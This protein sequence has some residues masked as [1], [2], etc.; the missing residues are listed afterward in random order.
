[1][2]ILD[3]KTI[4]EKIKEA[5]PKECEVV[6]IAP[7]GL[8]I[9]VY[10]K[11]IRAFYGEEQ[12]IKK[13]A[14][15]IKR[16]ISVRSDPSVLTPPEEAKRIITELV[17][18]EAQLG[19]I[20]FVPE[21]SKVL[22]EAF[23]PGVVI[24]K[25]GQTLREIILRT[26]WSPK[27]LRIPTIESSTLSGMR[28]SYV[29]NAKAIKKFLGTLGKKLTLNGSDGSPSWIRVSFLGA[30]QEVGRSCYYIQTNKERFLLD[31]G[32]N[33]ETS[34]LKNAFPHIGDA[35]LMVEK[36]DGVILSHAHLDHCGFLPFL[37]KIGYDGPVYC[38][39]P[40]KDLM[41]LLINDLLDIWQK[42]SN[43]PLPYT[44][45]D[46]QNLL[47]H[48]VTVE[49]GEVIDISQNTK[50]TFYNAGHILGSAMVHLHI[51]EGMHNIVYTGDIKY[52]F[53]RLF[54]PADPSFPKVD[55]LIIEST[56][57]GKSDEMPERPVIESNLYSEIKETVSKKGK[58]L[59]PVFSVGRAQEIMLTLEE[60]ARN[61]KDWNIPVYLD[62]MSL[63]ASA[64]HTA[65]P[66]YL[67]K[68]VQARVLSNDSPFES[69][70]FKVVKGTSREEIVNGE[71][72][73]VLAPSGM[74]TGGPV[75]DFFR[76]MAD[77]PKNKLI[78]V[79]YQSATS[80][81][82]KIQQ[83]TKEIALPGSNGKTEL[84]KVNMEVKT[85]D[86]FSGHS[87]RKQLLNFARKLR[88]HVSK[89]YTIHGEPTKAIDLAKALANVLHCEARAP[90]NLE[91]F[92]LR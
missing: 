19:N 60:F 20:Y 7:E 40:T 27:I 63:E 37:Y 23:K 6:S 11:N 31:F 36:L 53:T 57:G 15:L 67:R 41:V 4:E 81:G 88:G 25:G 72:S 48:T 10:V 17:S 66:E 78:F 30:S 33:P 3:L 38:T 51:G 80:L 87:D 12:L 47:Q 82:R 32:I 85:V 21:F 65:Y 8:E 26:G 2:Y 16:K 70:I 59:I 52:G 69:E 29:A 61:D 18:Q 28:K 54:N 76:L 24:G 89:V 73:I 22:I 14:S 56:Y 39:P 83:G 62:G 9:V 43:H 44:I 55:T 77:D 58:V 84:V 1:M 46:V 75:V 13:L 74:M 5:V 71:P 42:Y 68:N 34:D 50:L 90:M 49:Y 91:S 79:G 45:R 92:R 35:D 64:I 86:G